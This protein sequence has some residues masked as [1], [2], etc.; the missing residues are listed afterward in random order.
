MQQ[1]NAAIAAGTWPA[2]SPSYLYGWGNGANGRIGLGNTTTYSSPKQVGSLA[3]WSQISSAAYNIGW[4]IA[5]KKDGTL[6]SWGGNNVGQLGLNNLTYYSS[7]KQVGALTVWVNVSAGKDHALAIRTNG[8]LWSWGYNGFGALGLSSY[9]TQS[10]PTQVGSLTN[11]AFVSCGTDYSFAL[12][13]NGTLWSWG[14]NGNGNL[15]LSNTTT[16]NSPV[17]VGALTTWASV[18]C[19]SNFTSAIKTDGTLWTWGNNYY[20]A[21]GLNSGATYINS[22]NQVGAL[23]TWAKVGANSAA[24]NNVAIKTDGTIW[25]WG[26]NNFGQMG[27]GNATNYSS[28]KQ[29]GSLTTWLNASAGYNNTMAIS[30]S[31]S[32]WAL[33][34]KNVYGQLGLNNTAYYSSPKQVG[35]QNTW[36]TVSSGRDFMLATKGS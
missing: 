19:G 29:V 24:A 12:K 36:L 17:Q 10:S 8:T 22:P 26:K 13:T 21:L 3:T 16:Y 11:W 25:T 2:G 1:V 35:S 27:I 7:P 32:L 20:G 15:G 4:S 23:T 18:S 9:T 30:T 5:V 31:G 34:G 14:Y 28:P 6:W 33:G